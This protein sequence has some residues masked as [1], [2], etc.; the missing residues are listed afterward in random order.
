MRE[1]AVVGMT[2]DPTIFQK[3]IADGDAYD[4]Q[5]HDVLEHQSDPK[6]VFLALASRDI[7][8]ACDL[9]RST[10]ERTKHLGRQV[11]LEVD[12]GLADDRDGTIAE[13]Q[14]LHQLVDRQNLYVKIPATE[15]GLKEYRVARS[16]APKGPSTACATCQVDR[17]QDWAA[18]EERQ[19]RD[20]QG[21]R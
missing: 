20:L 13:A 6:E 19:Q 14:R 21:V 7:R 3:A 4:E 15:S 17:R 11:S 16:R 18:D 8:S 10:W 12:P 9:L 2:S 1:D 5:L